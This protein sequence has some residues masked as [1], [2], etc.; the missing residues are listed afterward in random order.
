MKPDSTVP[1]WPSE[2]VTRRLENCR[3]M[4]AIHGFL[5]ASESEKVEKRIQRWIKNGL[6]MKSK[7]AK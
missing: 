1:K 6:K 3:K 7:P 4:L 5:S 2:L